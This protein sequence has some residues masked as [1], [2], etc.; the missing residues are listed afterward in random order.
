MTLLVVSGMSDSV[1]DRTNISS[2]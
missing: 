2:L 1:I